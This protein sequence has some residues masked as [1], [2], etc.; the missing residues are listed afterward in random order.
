MVAV[1]KEYVIEVRTRKDKASCRE[2][3]SCIHLLSE[4]QWGK[5]TSV[6]RNGYPNQGGG[7]VK[8]T[9]QST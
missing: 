9:A 5:L 3:V 7:W 2:E 8:G 4:D 6:T 1:R